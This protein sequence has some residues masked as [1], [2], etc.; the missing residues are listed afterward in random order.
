MGSYD[1]SIEDIREE[2]EQEIAWG[3]SVIWELLS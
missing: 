1:F 2:L 3:L